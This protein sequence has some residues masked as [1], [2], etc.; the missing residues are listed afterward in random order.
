LT[1]QKL[2]MSQQPDEEPS[3]PVKAVWYATELFGKFA[4]AVRDPPTDAGSSTTTLAAKPTSLDEA[5]E[6]L[7]ADYEGTPDDPRPYFVV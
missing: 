6:R 1:Q 4:T 3:L 2:A 5:I 7:Q